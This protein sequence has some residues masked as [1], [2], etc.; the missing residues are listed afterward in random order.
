M[1]WKSQ[2]F[3]RGA[4]ALLLLATLGGVYVKL[5]PY[6]LLYQSAIMVVALAWLFWIPGKVRP[7][8][9]RRGVLDSCL[10]ALVILF[11]G[12][13]LLNIFFSVDR[14]ASLALFGQWISFGLIG[15]MAAT[16][17]SDNSS[18]KAFVQY[19]LVLGVLMCGLGI[20][21]YWGEVG[22]VSLPVM[23]SIFGN[24]NHFAGYLLLLLPLAFAMYLHASRPR[25][26][27]AYGA[28]GVLFASSLILTYSRGA[29]FAAVP[30]FVLI[31]WAARALGTSSLMRRTLVFLFL[32]GVTAFLTSRGGM[33]YA[34]GTGSQA[35]ASVAATAIGQQPEGTLAPR[36]DYWQGA[37]RIM[38]DNP[39]LGT[40]LD[41]F[42][43]IFPEY[44]VDPRFYS[45]FAH[46]FFLQSGAEMGFPGLVVGLALFI[47]LALVGGQVL[48]FYRGTIINPVAAG[49]VSSLGASVLHNLVELDWYLPSIG[50]LFAFEVGLVFAWRRLCIE[51]DA[52]SALDI[53][54][55]I[56]KPRSFNSFWTWGGRLLCIALF[57]AMSFQAAGQIL[58]KRG[59]SLAE[60]SSW[61]QA[62]ESFRMAAS[63]VP[64]DAWPYFRLADIYWQR[65]QFDGRRGDLDK[66]VVLA[67]EAVKRSPRFSGYRSLLARLYL[68]GDSDGQPV[69]NK[70]EAELEQIV[71]ALPAFQAPS[72]YQLLGQVYLAQG[73]FLEAKRIYLDILKAYPKGVDSPQ[74]LPGA[75]SPEKM[76]E[77]LG[78]AHM[79]LGNIYLQE[80]DRD[81][82]EREYRLVLGLLPQHPAAL[83]NMGIIYFEEGKTSQALDQFQGSLVS[84]P[85]YAPAYYYEGLSYIQLGEREKAKSSLQAALKVKPDYREAAQALN[86]LGGL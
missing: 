79:A 38:K 26:M 48:G 25:E 10:L 50:V 46:N 80:Q 63:L 41:T 20:Y 30:A 67:S 35:V 24:K 73:R 77:L 47:L 31:F 34:L 54:S 51:Q 52:V 11:A 45:K 29:W 12:M 64:L 15:L 65:F 23:N 60:A 19:L 82:A 40:G 83:F 28:T 69:R 7:V 56:T 16:L 59:E 55:S 84:N 43:T 33:G 2:A 21:F 8:R 76:A 32:A 86:A 27:L 72:S 39:L 18:F 81:S 5:S 6:N 42:Q 66:A 62:E 9:S 74:P 61:V 14:A 37:L 75:L 13:A 71:R 57:L 70:A 44:Q 3:F 58:L 17:V 78:E 36:L 22:R 1:K 4:L 53:S 49:L 68:A 85:Q